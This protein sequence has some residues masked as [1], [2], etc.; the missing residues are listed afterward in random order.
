MEFV[1][2]L[3]GSPLCLVTELPLFV[4]G[5]KGKKHPGKPVSYLKFKKKLPDIRNRLTKGQSIDA[6][7]QQFQIRPTNI[8]V[9][10][11]LHL[12]TL[13]LGLTAITSD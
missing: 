8:D 10:V 1:R 7:V 2:S 5:K 13:A 6:F 3:G 11:N 12:R 4:I 9:H